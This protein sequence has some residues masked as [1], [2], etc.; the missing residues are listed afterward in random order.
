[1]KQQIKQ[2]AHR[3]WMPVPCPG[4]LTHATDAAFWDRISGQTCGHCKQPI[5]YGCGVYVYWPRGD[6]AHIRC[7]DETEG[8]I[9]ALRSSAFMVDAAAKLAG[10]TQEGFRALAVWEKDRLIA[11]VTEAKDVQ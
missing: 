2:E 8:K 3:E 7:T 1:M 11:E 9:I 10:I 5:G 4:T 6:A